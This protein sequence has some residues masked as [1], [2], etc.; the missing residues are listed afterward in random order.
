MK[1]LV[2]G[3][4]EKPARYAY[5]AVVS[6]LK[7][8]HEVVALAKMSGEVKGV[9]FETKHIEYKNIDTI[10]LYINPQIQLAYYDYVVSLH[11]RRVIFNPGTENS[12]FMDLLKQYDIE[13]VIACTLV[14]LSTNQF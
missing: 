14:M 7:H 5:K 6:L 9:E 10:T 2:I 4:S 11:P 3:V 12:E 13:F 1:T 8:G